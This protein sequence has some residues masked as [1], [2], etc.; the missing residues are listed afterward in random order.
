MKKIMT[1][2]IVFAL[3][4]GTAF[5]EDASLSKAQ[6]LF[7]RYQDLGH[8]FSPSLAGLYSDDS[9]ITAQRGSRSLSFTG[10]QWKQVLAAGLP[11]AKSAGDIDDYSGISYTKAGS[12][13]LV[14]ATRYSR[15]KR[16]KTPYSAL[17]GPDTSGSWKIL[18]EQIVSQP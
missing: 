11:A 7:Q 3:V 1:L 18:R 8:A 2:L 10:R 17:L 13:V 14:K 12:N 15:L 16:A 4:M 5:A 9:V 6:G